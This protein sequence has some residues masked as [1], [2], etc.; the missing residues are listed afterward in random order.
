M[1]YSLVD[2]KFIFLHHCSPMSFIDILISLISFLG[3]PI[4][5]TSFIYLYYII[6]S[7]FK[8][9]EYNFNFNIIFPAF[10]HNLVKD[11]I[12]SIVDFHYLNPCWL[13]PTCTVLCTITNVWLKYLV[14]KTSSEWLHTAIGSSLAAEF[15]YFWFSKG[16]VLSFNDTDLS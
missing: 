3:S 10:L 12:A 4:I 2:S 6:T 14:I 7:L 11:V 1:L 15:L 8:V 16:L 13:A 9:Y 5:C